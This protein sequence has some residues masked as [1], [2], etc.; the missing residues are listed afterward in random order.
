MKL[1][2][3]QLRKLVESTVKD[4]MKETQDSDL[5]PHCPE[6]GSFDVDLNPSWIKKNSDELI[7]FCHGCGLKF[8][9]DET[10]YHSHSKVSYNENEFE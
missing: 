9:D 1:T 6:C 7:N 5:L 3:L 2:L 8:Y 10:D 4:V